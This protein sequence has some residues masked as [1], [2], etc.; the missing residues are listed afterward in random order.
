MP[1]IFP[2]MVRLL[3][4]AASLA[5]ASPVV[6]QDTAPIAID[7]NPYRFAKD[8][9][10]LDR[11]SPLELWDA[12]DY[13][14][15]IEEPAQ[16]TRFLDAFLARKPDDATLLQVRD[17]FGLGSILRLQDSPAI[18]ARAR[19]LLNLVA[20]AARRGA[21]GP[22]R[23]DA[24]IV[25]LGATPEEADFAL[26]RLR[27][28]GPDAVPAIARALADPKLDG[29]VKERIAGRLGGLDRAA[30]P[31][32]LALLD[33]PDPALAAAAARALGGIGD[34]RAISDLTYLANAPG[35]AP[36]LK[37]AAGRSLQT[38]NH[39]QVSAKPSSVLTSTARAYLNHEV[40]FP[41]GPFEVWAWQGGG[42]SA[43]R[44][45][46]DQAEAMLGQ[47]AA[48]RALALDPEDADARAVLI[49]LT[50]RASADK[51]GDPSKLADGDPTGGFA[52]AVQAGPDILARVLRSA[53]A[54]GDADVASAAAL[55]L[56]KVAPS[57]GDRRLPL[58][59]DAL[60][61]PDRRIRFAAAR[62]IVDLNPR[63]AFP[64]S[65][66]VVAALL[67]F[68]ASGSAPRAIIVDGNTLRANAAAGVMTSLGYDPTTTSR[69]E[70]GFV[71]AARSA[72][73][74]AILIEPSGLQGTYGA[75]DLLV[76]LRADA[77]TA[78]IPVYLLTPEDVGR[79][80]ARATQLDV[81][82]AESEDNS[83][84]DRANPL[85]FTTR[86]RQ[87]RID[88]TLTKIDGNG[89]LFLVGRLDAGDALAAT[90]V[91]PVYGTLKRSNVSVILER[92]EVGGPNSLAVAQAKGS[93]DVTIK[94]AG[95][96][97]VRLKGTDRERGDGAHYELDV[98]LADKTPTSVG[99][100]A[101][102]QRLDA[103]AARFPRVAVVGA[104]TDPGL[105]RRQIVAAGKSLEA[106]P[107]SEAERGSYVQAAADL[108]AKIVGDPT[109]PMAEVAASAG[110]ELVEALDRAPMAA[111]ALGGCVG[112]AAQRALADRVLNASND[113]AARR[114]AAEALGRSLRRYGPLVTA[115]QALRLV[116][117]AD[118]EPA[119]EVRGALGAVGGLLRPRA[120]GA[121]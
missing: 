2:R 64:G 59:V 48:R 30:V 73:V 54:R 82:R 66:R 116:R 16:A 29:A 117:A 15:K 74:E 109:G 85:A 69:G 26:E 104:S 44:L 37:E 68:L 49:G 84:A 102:V 17:R 3:A 111:S 60:D 77:R 21:T 4:L 18:A 46:R 113:P 10:L 35:V 33:A 96:Y 41:E 75:R 119:G 32:L 120:P 105:L 72:D 42:L 99:G 81:A 71:E 43:R 39:G 93:L 36:A 27:E 114:Q 108:L 103:L 50:L 79:I 23:L 94:Q 78:G 12:V 8:P 57:A 19:P 76:N 31:P 61:A 55:A 24:L 56:T 58:L 13:L 88:G 107:L 92:G 52:S 53:V 91:V 87:A 25:G 97:Y 118:A 89:D 101:I 51:A 20:E 65:S 115:D 90:V 63:V 7:T 70:Q 83:T 6:G 98:A 110:A 40:P 5:L 100:A 1:R 47:R 67:P 112:I 95:T 121:R 80:Q 9:T 38:L 28:A 45:V 34:P 14:V 62:A 106:R 11:W 22:A 86:P